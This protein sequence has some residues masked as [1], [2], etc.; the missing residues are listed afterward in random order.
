MPLLTDG[1]RWLKAGTLSVQLIT[2][3]GRFV[4]SVA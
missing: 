2:S 3:L 4:A 1:C